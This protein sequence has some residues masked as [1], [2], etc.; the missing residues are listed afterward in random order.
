MPND[1]I[2]DS[3]TAAQ[4]DAGNVVTALNYQLCRVRIYSVSI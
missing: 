4:T 2:I 3:D 1:R